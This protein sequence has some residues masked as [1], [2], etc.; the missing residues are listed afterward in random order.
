MNNYTFN[1]D[2]VWITIKLHCRHRYGHECKYSMVER[3][4]V[5][6]PKGCPIWKIMLKIENEKEN[7]ETMPNGTYG[8]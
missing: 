6:N 1:D 3:K 8:E 5:K 4:C 7:N 2:L